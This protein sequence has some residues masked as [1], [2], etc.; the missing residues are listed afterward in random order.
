MKK[1]KN[2]FTLI[3]LLVVVLIIGIL[4]AVALPQ[5]K[6]AVEKSRATEAITNLNYIHKRMQVRALEC[7]YTDDCLRD[8][9]NYVELNG[10]EWLDNIQYQTK[11]FLYDTDYELCAY[12]NKYVICFGNAENWEGIVNENSKTCEIQNQLYCKV[13]KDLGSEYTT[14]GCN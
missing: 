13:C 11:Y 1:I 3:E 14:Y 9:K 8:M 5:Y 10:G 6:V 12:N 4:A 7:G 2:G